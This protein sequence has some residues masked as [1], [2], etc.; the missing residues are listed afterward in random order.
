MNKNINHVSFVQTILKYLPQIDIFTFTFT[1]NFL[2]SFSVIVNQSIGW[3]EFIILTTT[4]ENYH[5]FT[6]DCI[7]FNLKTNSLRVVFFLYLN[8]FVASLTGFEVNCI[9]L[10]RQSCLCSSRTQ[11]AFRDRPNISEKRVHNII[12]QN[13]HHYNYLQMKIF[14][15]FFNYILTQGHF[16]SSPTHYII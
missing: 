4:I 8:R 10:F 13:F 14:H 7:E 3:I 16:Q 1:M 12:K 15:R 5:K 6:W 2:S 11:G 9:N